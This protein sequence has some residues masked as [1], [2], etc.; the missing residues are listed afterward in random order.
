[1]NL[2][3]SDFDEAYSRDACQQ[4][5]PECKPGN[6]FIASYPPVTKAGTIGPFFTNTHLARPERKF[7][8]VGPV[9]VRSKDF[10]KK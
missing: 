1:M 9:P 10:K 3:V 8:V 6:C 2:S 4:P 7:E 5:R